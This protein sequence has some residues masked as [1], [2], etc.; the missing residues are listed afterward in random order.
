MTKVLI[1]TDNNNNNNGDDINIGIDLKRLGANRKKKDEIRVDK[2]TNMNS[3]MKKKLK[4]IQQI[5]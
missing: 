2:E 3:I 4:F 5:V 1:T